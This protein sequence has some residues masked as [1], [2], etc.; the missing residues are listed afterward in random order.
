MK[1]WTFFIFSLFISYLF[2]V[3]N[4][5]LSKVSET[6]STWLFP[7]SLKP[8]SLVVGG[9]NHVLRKSVN[10]SYKRQ[11]SAKSLASEC[12]VTSGRSLMKAKNRR[13]PRNVP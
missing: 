9:M 13:G 1:I 2:P 7:I 12:F 4:A 11:S 3:S 6:A 10:I 8:T 5:R